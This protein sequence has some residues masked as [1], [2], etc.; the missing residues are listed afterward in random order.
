MTA[1][2]VVREGW[3]RNRTDDRLSPS[4]RFLEDGWRLVLIG[5]RPGPDGR[6]ESAKVGTGRRYLVQA[7]QWRRNRGRPVPF[8]S[9]RVAVPNMLKNL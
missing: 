3:N 1:S 4:G 5:V 9:G 7:K 8:V 2:A 6:P